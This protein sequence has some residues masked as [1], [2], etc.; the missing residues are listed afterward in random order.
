MASD[1]EVLT[2][3]PTSSHLTAHCPGARWRSVWWSQENRIILKEQRSN[4]SNKTLLPLATP[5]DPIH[6]NHRLLQGTA[7]VEPN[8]RERGKE[9]T[10]LVLEEKMQSVSSFSRQARLLVAQRCFS[11]LPNTRKWL[12]NIAS[13]PAARFGM[14]NLFFW[15]LCLHLR[16]MV[17]NRTALQ[18]FIEKIKSNKLSRSKFSKPS[19]LFINTFLRWHIVVCSDLVPICQCFS[20]P[21]QMT[22]PS[23]DSQDSFLICCSS[24]SVRRC[25]LEM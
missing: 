23:N 10:L 19:M 22:I 1:M 2:V 16:A 14:R 11:G 4:S 5:W 6:E 3:I 8:T 9:M 13:H 25:E 18:Y 7:L 15:D 24:G 20:Q 17:V 21:L 12:K